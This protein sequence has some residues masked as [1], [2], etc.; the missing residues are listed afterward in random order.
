MSSVV[1]CGGSVLG[2]TSAMLL[3]RDGH[4]VLVLEADPAAVPHDAIEAW[5]RWPRRGVPQFRQPH[6]LFP[7]FRQV[8]DDELPGLVDELLETGCVPGHLL[9]VTPPT[10]PDHRPRPD[11]DRFRFVAGRRP[12]VELA[13]ARAAEREPNVEIRRGV[14]VAGLTADSSGNGVPHV[15]GVVADGEVIKADLVVDAMGR[16]SPVIEWLEALG[17]PSP[18]RESSDVGFVYY[19]RYF[20]GP[21]LPRQVGPPSAP[22]GTFSI[23]TLPGDNDT[24]SVTLYGSGRDTRFKQVRDPECFNRVVHALPA[25]AHWLQGEPITDV[26]AMAGVVD[27]YRRFVVAGRPV[28]TGFAAVG[29]AWA[30]TNPSAGRGLTVGAVHAVLLRDAVRAYGDDPELFALAFDKATESAATPWYRL[31]RTMDAERFAEIAALREGR[32]PPPG[33]ERM[34]AFGLAMA[35]DADVFRAFA[36]T[37][38]CLA[39]PDEVLARPGMA[40]RI[41]PW[42]TSLPLQM[43]APSREKLEQLLV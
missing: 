5:D 14:R 16:R 39:L 10:L 35:H 15:T 1:V 42:R 38:A 37:I 27:R 34:R 21:K 18:Y 12:A 28:A 11:D 8:L 7:R 17:A 13:F 2:L 31:Q 32:E 26:L 4:S 25:H 40:E 19:T 6:N 20:T 29:D 41:A 24:W 22:M 36:E 9:S 30:C 33:D 23:L 43:P 3:A